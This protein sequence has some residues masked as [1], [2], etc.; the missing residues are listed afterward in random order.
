MIPTGNKLYCDHTIELMVN[1][2]GEISHT[3]GIAFNVSFRELAVQKKTFFGF[4]RTHVA[5]RVRFFPQ[6][7]FFV[8]FFHFLNGFVPQNRSLN[9]NML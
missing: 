9:N 3:V 1:V 5:V 6:I 7:F 2:Y 4:L 8:F